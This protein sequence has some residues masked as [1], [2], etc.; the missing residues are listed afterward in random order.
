MAQ[1]WSVDWNTI[2]GGGVLESETADQLWQLAGTI[3]QWDSTSSQALSSSGVRLTGGFWSLIVNPGDSLFRDRFEEPP[4][5][6]PLRLKVEGGEGG[7]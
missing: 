4:S 7:S 5:P 2:D 6:A 1:D 3:G